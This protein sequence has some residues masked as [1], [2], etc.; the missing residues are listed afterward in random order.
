M[1]KFG[2]FYKNTHCLL[3]RND[4]MSIVYISS[5]ACYYFA[6]FK[7]FL[8][9]QNFLRLVFTLWHMDDTQG[10]NTYLNSSVRRY[11][12]TFCSHAKHFLFK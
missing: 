1:L 4:T 9:G 5:H 2:Q 3:L 8:M 11:W 10:K 12:T 7:Y 6:L